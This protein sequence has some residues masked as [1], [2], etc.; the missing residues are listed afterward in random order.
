[1]GIIIIHILEKYKCQISIHPNSTT[2]QTRTLSSDTWVSPL[3]SFSE[4]SVPPTELPNPELVFAQLSSSSLSS[5]SNPLSPL[6]WRV[7]LVF[8]DLSSPC[9]SMET[10][11]RPVSNRW[12][13]VLTTT[14]LTLDTN[15]SEPDFAMVSPPS[16]LAS[17]SES[18]AMLPSV[19]TPRKTWL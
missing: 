14:V 9:F 5:S 1:M 3:P 6:S 13:L 2:I 10:L 16:P 18:S 17:P 11:S 7:F 15:S 12:P 8:M 4:T 19:Q